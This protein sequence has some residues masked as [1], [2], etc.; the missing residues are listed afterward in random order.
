MDERGFQ[1]KQGW[2]FFHSPS[3]LDL[4]RSPTSLLSNGVPGA[5]SLGIKR[6]G[7]KA[8]NSPPSSTEIKN[9]WSYTS[10]P[11]KPP[12]HG[13]QLKKSQGQLH[14]YLDLHIYMIMNIVSNAKYWLFYNFI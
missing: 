13:A 3:L 10:I 12:L 4:Y 11:P 2:E 1:S 6:R 14:L 9:A 8:D 7:R 5:V